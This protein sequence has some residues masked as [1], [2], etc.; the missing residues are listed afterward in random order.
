MFIC[1]AIIGIGAAVVLNG[2]RLKKV[3]VSGNK[4]YDDTQIRQWVLN[5]EYSDNAPYVFLKYRFTEPKEVPFIDTMEIT[6]KS[7]NTVHV[8]VYE[9]GMLG[10]VYMDSIGKNIYFDK[11]GFVVEM[12][13]KKIKNV[14]KVTGLTCSKVLLYEQLQLD[15]KG[16]LKG[17]LAL[18][19][20]L[21][22]FSL[23]PDKIAYESG[24][25]YVLYF[26]KIT[27]QIGDGAHLEDKVARL[28]TILS[29]L[30]GKKGVLHL[31][32]WSDTNA[33]IV[34]QSTE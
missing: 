13:S 5:D 24:G 32:K 1:A 23:E 15:Q 4:L 30:E 14:P 16:V 33:E 2:F 29:K 31:E 26:K 20:M 9:K 28:Q 21:K 7:P 25:N 6:L 3:Q 8:K 17:L 22:K 12:S 19:N 11:D 34:F 10:Y 27:V 18:T